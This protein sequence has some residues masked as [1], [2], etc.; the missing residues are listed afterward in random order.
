M[1][2]IENLENANYKIKLIT[3]YLFT[4]KKK[5]KPVLKFC[6][7]FMCA[8]HSSIRSQHVAYPIIHLKCLSIPVWYCVKLFPLPTMQQMP[9]LWTCTVLCLYSTVPV[10]IP[11]EM[12]NSWLDMALP[13]S[14][15]W[16]KPCCA[17]VNY[18]FCYIT[19]D[20]YSQGYVMT[21]LFSIMLKD[22]HW[23]LISLLLPILPLPS[24]WRSLD[25][26]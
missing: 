21:C 8:N 24:P 26:L 9:S 25:L 18:F 16:L 7:Y 11:M 19:D 6:W 17:S 3:D 5:R 2:T 14:S 10:K 12:K 13:F 22:L 4:R 15:N 23:A 1:T 20:S